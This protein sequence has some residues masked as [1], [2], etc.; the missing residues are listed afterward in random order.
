M[1]SGAAGATG[2]SG[3]TPAAGSGRLRSDYTRPPSAGALSRTPARSAGAGAKDAAQQLAGDAHTP[4]SGI[5]AA[6]GG[7]GGYDALTPAYAHTNALYGVEDAGMTPSVRVREYTPSLGQQHGAG[8]GGGAGYAPP[9]YG[10][11]G[12]GPLTSGA[13]ASAAM[14]QHPR[15]LG[16][17]SP[18]L[19][20]HGDLW[21]APD[22]DDREAIALEVHAPSQ[23]CALAP[24]EA[25]AAAGAAAPPSPTAA[26]QSALL[27][28]PAWLRSRPFSTAHHLAGAA[29][30]QLDAEAEG[31]PAPDLRALPEAVRE[32]ALVDDL[33]YCFM[34]VPGRCVR[35]ALADDGGQRYLRGP[36]LAFAPA[37]AL[38][39]RS[40]ELVRKLLPL[41]EY[42]AVV[43]RFAVTRDR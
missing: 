4:G 6:G 10:A 15:K 21:V 1:G 39:E 19:A 24:G 31:E 8:G 36:A 26:P 42:A 11:D 16:A 25:A 18:F 29:A 40:A 32:A 7:A 13:A 2:A 9:G 35:P 14:Q 22:Q 3:R 12:V 34:G 20:T 43:E 33:L 41:P 27:V 30:P 23:A 37:A 5:P 38:D 28:L 17:P